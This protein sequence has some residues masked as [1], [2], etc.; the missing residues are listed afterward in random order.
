MS[1][2][3][4]ANSGL[5]KFYNIQVKN[6]KFVNIVNPT[7]QEVAKSVFCNEHR[8]RLKTENQTYDK[9]EIKEKLENEWKNLTVIEQQVYETFLLLKNKNNFQYESMLDFH[10]QN[11]LRVQCDNPSYAD[12]DKQK[13]VYKEKIRV[14]LDSEWN[15]IREREQQV[16]ESSL[17]LKNQNI[18]LIIKEEGYQSQ[19]D[20][21]L[22]NRLRVQNEN[23]TYEKKEIKIQLQSEWNFINFY[24]KGY[25]LF[26]MEF[27]K[28]IQEDNPLMDREDIIEE[29]D[30]NWKQ[31]SLNKRNEYY[32]K[33]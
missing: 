17:T 21:F 29:L 7:R 19:K 22:K 14:L 25:N 30:N 13:K 16:Y 10:N 2:Q 1:K 27:Y 31:M 32:Q 24:G 9:K 8:D 28:E 20:Y 18:D 3:A 23:P 26:C 6:K 4:V 12:N 15:T 33:C 5:S 11:R